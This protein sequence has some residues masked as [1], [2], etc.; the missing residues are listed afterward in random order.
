MD[1]NIVSL[2]FFFLFIHLQVCEQFDVLR[3]E[4]EHWKPEWE[5]LRQFSSLW[6]YGDD[7]LHIVYRVTE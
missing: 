1:C 4:S 6:Y 5:R 2:H 7:L 3:F